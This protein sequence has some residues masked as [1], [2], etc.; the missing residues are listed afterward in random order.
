MKKHFLN[1]FY[2]VQLQEQFFLL[3]AQLMI[4]P[5]LLTKVA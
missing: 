1:R 4:H 3:V 2:L 5:V